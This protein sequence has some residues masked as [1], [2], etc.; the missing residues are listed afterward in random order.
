M[1]EIIY[2]DEF[3]EW[4]KGLDKEDQERVFSVV[5]KLEVM[6]L[7]LKE[8]HSKPLHGTTY[9]IREL[10]AAGGRNAIRI[11]YAYDP[12]R[13]AVLILGGDKTGN[14]RFYDEMLPRVEAI[15][16]QY[17]EELQKRQEE[18]TKGK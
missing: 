10:R 7:A 9:A 1:S 15:W 13:N 2:T 18:E 14:P 4:F 5:D 3:G 17:L 6:G 11:F 8:P 12:E 16:K